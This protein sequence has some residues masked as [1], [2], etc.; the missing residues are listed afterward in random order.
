MYPISDIL[1]SGFDRQ[2]AR[3]AEEREQRQIER[4]LRNRRTAQICQERKK[5]ELE[6]LYQK[7]ARLEQLLVDY[8]D[9]NISLLGHI[10]QVERTGQRIND[11]AQQD[12]WSHVAL[13][14][15]PSCVNEIETLEKRPTGIAWTSNLP[16]E[17]VD[18]FFQPTVLSAVADPFL[19][20]L[21]Q[22]L[23]DNYVQP[24]VTNIVDV[25]STKSPCAPDT[26]KSIDCSLTG[27]IEQY[28]E[29]ETLDS[30]NSRA[31]TSD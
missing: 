21:D 29:M 3:T 18:S 8:Q 15:H 20:S 4:V 10:E 25:P 1:I 27:T 5:L 22:P 7:I 28:N 19:E 11:S 23:S 13:H 9:V 17:A 2:R 12:L 26:G 16:M 30:L 24:A 14:C 6:T 31:W